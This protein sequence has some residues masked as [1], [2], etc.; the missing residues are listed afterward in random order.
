M[1][2]LRNAPRSPA[3]QPGR[4]VISGRPEIPC[5][6]R[7]LSSLGARLSFMNPTILPRSFRVLFDD[8]DAKVTVIWQA[9][10]LAGVRFQ[11]PIRHLPAPKRR[12]WPWSRK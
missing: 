5:T 8:Q 10:V 3:R 1:P 4:I 11:T 12:S 6:I 9:G 7:D 2:D